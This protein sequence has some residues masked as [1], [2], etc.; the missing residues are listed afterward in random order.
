MS[1]RLIPEEHLATRVIVR[2]TDQQAISGTAGKFVSDQQ[3]VRT[4][5]GGIDAHTGNLLHHPGADLEES[6][7]NDRELGPSVWHRITQAS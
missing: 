6:L 5:R 7:V 2:R 3:S 4:G 1:S